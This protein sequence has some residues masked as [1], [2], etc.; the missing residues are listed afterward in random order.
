MKLTN[1]VEELKY[2]VEKQ[3]E[4]VDSGFE[5]QASS[6]RQLKELIDGLK[7]AKPEKSVDGSNPNQSS[8]LLSTDQDERTEKPVSFDK[9]S[10]ISMKDVTDLMQTFEDQFSRRISKVEA[11]R[12]E[13]TKALKAIR[14]QL[15]RKATK[16]QVIEGQIQVVEQVVNE[17]TKTEQH[18]DSLI[19]E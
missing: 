18:L 9:P 16:Q 14:G 8:K 12:K 13:N 5:S 17:E 4:R 7:A 19:K 11:K 1:L 2:S 3:K 15:D 10:G 6:I